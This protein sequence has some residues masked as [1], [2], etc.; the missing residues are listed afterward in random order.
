MDGTSSADLFSLQF[1]AGSYAPAGFL[2]HGRPATFFCTSG[3]GKHI[4]TSVN[5]EHVFRNAMI[6]IRS[7]VAD[8]RFSI[9]SSCDFVAEYQ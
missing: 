2:R 3:T 6:N 9:F 7:I 8:I 4:Q 1:I 5:N